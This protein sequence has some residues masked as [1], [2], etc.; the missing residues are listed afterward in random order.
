[1]NINT[2][3]QYRCNYNLLLEARA[4]QLQQITIII[5]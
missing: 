1:M 5:I 4:I 3:T 2:N